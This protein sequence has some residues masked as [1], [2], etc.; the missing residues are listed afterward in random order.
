MVITYSY[1]F[2]M[3]NNHQASFKRFLLLTTRACWPTAR[4]ACPPD[5]LSGLATV[6]TDTD[7]FVFPVGFDLS[8]SFL[9]M[10]D[11]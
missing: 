7:S 3:H 10:V 4:T 5:R 8:F 1:G 6:L 2:S 11:I 9:L